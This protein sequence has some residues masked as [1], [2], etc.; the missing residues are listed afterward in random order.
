MS[1]IKKPKWD[2]PTAGNASGGSFGPGTPMLSDACIDAGMTAHATHNSDEV[3]IGITK[4]ENKYD[5][6]G[7]IINIIPKTK[8]KTKTDLSVGDRVFINRFDIEVLIH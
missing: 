1:E 4:V 7:T 8:G 2:K 5:A 6:E 3:V